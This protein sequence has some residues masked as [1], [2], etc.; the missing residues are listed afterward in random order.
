MSNDV[1]ISRQIRSTLELTLLTRNPLWHDETDMLSLSCSLTRSLWQYD[2]DALWHA[3][4]HG[5]WHALWLV[6]SD[7]FSL[8][9][10]LWLVLSDT[11]SLTCSLGH[12]LSD[13]VSLTWS[14]WHALSDTL[15]NPNTTKIWH[16]TISLT[17]HGNLP[18]FFTT[19]R[20]STSQ[21][22]YVR[23]GNPFVS[24]AHMRDGP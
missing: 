11:I 17:I 10:S 12:D 6:L 15:T 16:E 13:M 24:P 8:T 2:S 23:H 22:I 5:L 21:R 1:L 3:L 7:S 19:D 9:R 18:A 14:L 4:W 20:R